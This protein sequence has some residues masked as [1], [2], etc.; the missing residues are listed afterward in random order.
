[1]KV[2]FEFSRELFKKYLS[3]KK[4]PYRI[5]LVLTILIY[6]FLVFL[7][8]KGV[9]WAQ[10]IPGSSVIILTL[11]CAFLFCIAG[12][13]GVNIS[14]RKHTYNCQLGVEGNTVT[15]MRPLQSNNYYLFVYY[16]LL[17]GDHHPM[18]GWHMDKVTS[19]QETECYYIVYGSGVY[20]RNV[21]MIEN[22]RR[23][24]KVK[25]PKWFSGMGLLMSLPSEYADGV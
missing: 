1:M 17:F 11:Y 22:Q 8:N 5:S 20:V 19:V 7:N 10:M 24:N 25:I 14:E 15:F 6:M 9:E 16:Y 21:R 2:D 3:H 13:L 18:S 4:L 12:L 23:I